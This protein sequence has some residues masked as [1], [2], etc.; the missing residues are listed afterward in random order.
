MKIADK[1]IL[2]DNGKIV[3]MG[4]HNELLKNNKYYQILLKK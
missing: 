2:L 1:L 4:K 3:G